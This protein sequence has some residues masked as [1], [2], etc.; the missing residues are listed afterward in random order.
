ML[1][2]L[3]LQAIGFII[4]AVLSIFHGIVFL[5]WPFGINTILI[6]GMGWVSYLIEVFP[7]LGIILNGFLFYM[8]FRLVMIALY[9]F[10]LLKHSRVQ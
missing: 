5:Q 10:R 4:G 3:L 2:Y 1:I 7:P 8:G 9:L 6:T